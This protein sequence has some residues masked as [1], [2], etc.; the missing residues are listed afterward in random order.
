MVSVIKKM[1][2]NNEKKLANGKIVL[3]LQRDLFNLIMG[4]YINSINE[5]DLNSQKVDFITKSIKRHYARTTYP[6]T[7]IFSYNDVAET[8]ITKQ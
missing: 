5:S 6:K 4:K 2:K 8:P 7:V 1:L 3:Y